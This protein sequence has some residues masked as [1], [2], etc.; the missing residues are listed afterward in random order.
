MALTKL[1]SSSPQ[2]VSQS[3]VDRNFL[4]AVVL[5]SRTHLVLLQ[6]AI[7]LLLEA[8]R[9]YFGCTRIEL[10]SGI[11]ATVQLCSGSIPSAKRMCLAR[12]SCSVSKAASQKFIQTVH[13]HRAP[14]PVYFE[15]ERVAEQDLGTYVSHNVEMI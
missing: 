6:A 12:G 4:S 2:R 9:M 5:I 13:F 15:F 8:S 11:S 1:S 7:E 14:A 3:P 10:G